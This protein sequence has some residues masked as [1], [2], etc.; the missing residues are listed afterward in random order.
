MDPGAMGMRQGSVSM[1][2]IHAAMTIHIALEA[3]DRAAAEL[4]G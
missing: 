4:V 1:R 3:G 2:C